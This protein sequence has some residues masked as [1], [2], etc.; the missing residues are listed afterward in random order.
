[1][2]VESGADAALALEVQRGGI[3]GQPGAKRSGGLSLTR[4]AS[5]ASKPMTWEI[6][7]ILHVSSDSTKSLPQEWLA[8]F[9]DAGRNRTDCQN[10]VKGDAQECPSH[11]ERRASTR[12][13]F[14]TQ[15]ASNPIGKSAVLPFPGGRI[16]NPDSG[17]GGRIQGVHHEVK[18]LSTHGCLACFHLHDPRSLAQDQGGAKPSDTASETSAPKS[19]PAPP[20]GVQPPDPDK[21][22]HDGGELTLKP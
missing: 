9:G 8:A 11:T 17:W 3:P 15:S 4:D 2:Q 16:M 22:K 20:V 19:T 5:V 21:V 12:I 13:T 7:W 14:K 10:D 1:M 6:S 18:A